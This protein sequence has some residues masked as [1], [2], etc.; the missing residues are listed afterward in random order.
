[1]QLHIFHGTETGTAEILAQDIKAELGATHTCIVKSLDEVGPS[2]LSTENLNVIVCST[3]GS[4]DLPYSATAFYE[5][6][7]RDKPDL[8]GIEFAIF[9]LG[10]STFHD[11]FA[12]GSEKL[13]GALIDCGAKMRGERATFDSYSSSLPEDICLPWLSAILGIEPNQA[14]PALFNGAASKLRGFLS[15]KS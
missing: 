10:D 4:G 15:R 1:M 2:D 6:L 11:T 5:G 13:M 9:G 7:Q 3:Y 12:Q 8:S 14:A